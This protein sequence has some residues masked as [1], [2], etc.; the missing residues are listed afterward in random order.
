MSRN[1][2]PDALIG[3]ID[4]DI[5][6]LVGKTAELGGTVVNDLSPLANGLFSDEVTVETLLPGQDKTLTEIFAQIPAEQNTKISIENDLRNLEEEIASKSIGPGMQSVNDYWSDN[7]TNFGR[8]GRI[9]FG[10]IDTNS[11]GVSTPLPGPMKN[12]L[13]AFVSYNYIVT[14]ACLS[15]AELNTPDV[16][17]RTAGMR[18]VVCRSSGGA[19][20][21]KVLTAFE[22]EGRKI[23]FY[24]DNI[25]MKQIIH[26]NP[27]SRGTNATS[28]S[29]DI[30][31]PY[32]MGLFVQAMQIA[33]REAGH[34]NFLEAPYALMF[35]F[36]GWDSNN[37]HWNAPRTRRIF[38]FKWI[39]GEFEVTTQGS[40]YNMRG[41][42]FNDQ[43]FSD[44]VQTMP[45][46]IEITGRTLNE[47]VQTG[48]GSLATVINTHL[49]RNV[50]SQSGVEPDEYVFIFPKDR[51]SVNQAIAS[52][53]D[54]EDHATATTEYA[55]E[56][57]GEPPPA[58]RVDTYNDADLQKAIDSIKTGSFIDA[59]NIQEYRNFLYNQKGYILKRSNLSETIK[60]FNENT[61]NVNAIGQAE[62]SI[63]DPLGPGAVP[64]G[65][66]SF[67]YDK[68][69]GLLKR[70]N[71]TIDPKRRSIKFEKGTK[72]QKM[73]E[74]L[75]LISLYG[76]NSGPDTVPDEKG[77]VDW[78]R[79][80]AN[81]YNIDNPAQEAQTGRPPRVIVYRIVP[82][83]VH[84]SVFASPN[85]AYSGYTAL[86]RQVARE[87]NY[88]YT[89]KNTDVL[90][91]NLQ[92]Q[93][94]FF[95]AISPTANKN[96]ASTDLSALANTASENEANEQYVIKKAATDV[97]G[98]GGTVNT[99]LGTEN[100]TA[101]AISETG[102]VEI[103]RRFNDALINSDVDLI[104]TTMK[105]WGDPYYLA[106]SGM[107]NY[108]AKESEYF[109]LTSD[110]TMDYQSG[111]VDIRLNFKTPIDIK[112]NGF[113]DFGETVNVDNFSGLY[114]VNTLTSSFSGGQFTQELMMIRRKN[115]Q[116][117]PVATSE[118]QS[119]LAQKEEKEK[120]KSEMRA[121]GATEEE[122]AFKILDADK[123]G[124]LSAGELQNVRN[125][126]EKEIYINQINTEKER[127]RINARIQSGR[128]GF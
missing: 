124:Q 5:S 53:G 12:P 69:N 52:V 55:Y 28:M 63:V 35:E 88:M 83:K 78:F 46:D 121:A 49:L 89:G 7:A 123:D 23:E 102:K 56:A 39:N 97:Q 114:M 79:I 13:N 126:E 36:V 37:N 21:A 31:E 14:L 40:V 115:Q 73:L 50:E 67:N 24:I 119:L 74:D 3:K 104:S 16:T 19:G 109:N 125:A 42:P 106:D 80:E 116:L 110:T 48:A 100:G 64:F 99:T 86:E 113:Y 61:E 25:E 75:V 112:E 127:K 98:D 118:K 96:K 29:F 60:K 58:R 105:I 117:T 76:E 66:A 2:N 41:V 51:S 120:I 82:W 9:D 30:I 34:R 57:F 8:T 20:E 101:G 38:P 33:A 54:E 90:E 87:Y 47:L 103:A 70:D 10:G 65:Q 45:V 26:P 15:S 43:A 122:I 81:I 128:S 84:Q 27:K 17:Y 95:Q 68:E 94:A 6:N 4:K 92:F 59:D 22:R 85:T 111:Q 108:N 62:I 71:I 93:N 77:M 107:G 11:P 1:F 91:F 44:A 32:S 18:H 72:I